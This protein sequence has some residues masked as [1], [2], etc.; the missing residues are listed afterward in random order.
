MRF[1]NFFILVG[2][3]FMGGGVCNGVMDLD[4]VVDVLM[5]VMDLVFGV[6]DLFWILFVMG[7][8][9]YW[10]VGEMDGIWFGWIVVVC[11]KDVLFVVFFVI[12]E[13]MIGIRVSYYILI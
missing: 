9:V 11:L 6:V 8:F 1:S 7:V 10:L 4:F 12:F 13:V 2:L 3:V 5:G